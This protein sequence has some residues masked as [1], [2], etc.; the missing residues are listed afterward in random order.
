MLYWN[1][2][3]NQGNLLPLS[4][5]YVLGMRR[6]RTGSHIPLIAFPWLLEFWHTLVIYVVLECMGNQG[7]LVPLS[8]CMAN[9]RK[10][11]GYHF[12]AIAFAWPGILVCTCNVC[13]TGIYGFA[14]TSRECH[15]TVYGLNKTFPSLD[16]WACDIASNRISIIHCVCTRHT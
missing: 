4:L 1:V 16:C 7:N 12:T 3:E 2:W 9:E 15:T 10:G 14:R 8:W 6:N 11:T 5:A 13:S